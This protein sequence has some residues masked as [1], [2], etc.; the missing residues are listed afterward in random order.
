MSIRSAARNLRRASRRASAA[1]GRGAA[2]GLVLAIGE[3]SQTAR[4]ASRAVKSIITVVPPSLVMS[5]CV[6]S[7]AISGSP[8]PSP[9]LS[10]S[11]AH[12]E[13]RDR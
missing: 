8:R 6:A 10:V 12:P 4:Q 3:A 1:A 11:R 7:W 9:G 2:R 5:T 13:P